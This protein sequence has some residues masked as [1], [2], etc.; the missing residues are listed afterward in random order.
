MGL[1]IQLTHPK[2][3]RDL[4]VLIT[5]SRVSSRQ[6]CS[7]SSV[8]GEESKQKAGAGTRTP[9]HPWYFWLLTRTE[10]RTFFGF[11]L[12]MSIK[13][14]HFWG[15]SLQRHHWFQFPPLWQSPSVLY[16][17]RAC[18]RLSPRC[19]PLLLPGPLSPRHSH[20]FLCC[21]SFMVVR[22]GDVCRPCLNA[23]LFSCNFCLF[24]H[25]YLIHLRS[26]WQSP[27]RKR[28]PC[29]SDPPLFLS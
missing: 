27:C 2:L 12:G 10:A 1:S 11:Q 25:C 8:K 6:R 5:S 21:S 24:C 15:W 28:R 9:N 19:S 18:F 4:S 23:T 22:K 26:A 17:T 14:G 16:P 29:V 13:A 3:S 7:F 20:G